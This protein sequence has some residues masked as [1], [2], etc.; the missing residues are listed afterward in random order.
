[1]AQ[2][3]RALTI[4]MKSMDQ[5]IPD[6]ITAGAGDANGRTLRIIF[7][8]EAAAQFTPETKVYLSWHHQEKDISGLNIFQQISEE[9]PVWQISY[10]QNML[11]EGNVL[12][13]IKLVD[14]ISIVQSVDFLIH[15]IK[16]PDD[17]SNFV[18]SDD[19]TVFQNAIIDLSSAAKEARDQIAAQ[20][21]EFE[22]M[23][24]S[25]A[26]IQEQL[27]DVAD[28]LEKLDN[29][30]DLYDKT[31]EANEK[32]NFAYEKVLELQDKVVNTENAVGIYISEME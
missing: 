11:W 5:D 14:S 20:K 15:V 18:V 12:A 1:M 30:N 3:L 26:E 9:P 24:V 13:C 22:Q 2:E 7:S 4:N 31:E 17:G 29:I 8:Q 27:V 28:K 6:P 25:F 10:P 32:A 23:Q 16:D 19:Y 21:E